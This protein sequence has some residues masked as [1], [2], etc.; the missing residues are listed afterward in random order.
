MGV[1]FE[2]IASSSTSA[3]LTT[4]KRSNCEEAS[5]SLNPW[6]PKTVPE[7]EHR[8]ANECEQRPG[9][10]VRG[11]STVIYG[12]RCRLWSGGHVG[13]VRSGPGLRKS[14]HFRSFLTCLQFAVEV[15][16]FS[17]AAASAG[18]QQTHTRKRLRQHPSDEPERFKVSHGGEQSNAPFSPNICQHHYATLLESHGST[19]V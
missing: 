14:G 18:D 4:R 9:Q 2:A 8:H 6:I 16:V 10:H 5:R 1:Q 13:D 17:S 12:H 11:F 3:S 15:C 19:V 7:Y